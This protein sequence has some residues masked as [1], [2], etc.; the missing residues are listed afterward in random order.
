MNVNA[1]LL[2]KILANQIQQY[3][4]GI[5]YMIEWDLFKDLLNH[6]RMAQYSQINV[7]TPH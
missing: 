7:M 5:T 4:K 1:K 2:S 3:I 6:S